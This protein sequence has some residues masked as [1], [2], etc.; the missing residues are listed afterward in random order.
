MPLT[1]AGAKTT[2]DQLSRTYSVA[3]G[4]Q[5]SVTATSW[6]DLSTIYTIPAGDAIPG[7]YNPTSVTYRLTSGGVG[8]WGNGESLQFRG[9]IGSNN[10]GA[11]GSSVDGSALA[12]G[13]AFRWWC[14]VILVVDVTGASGS[15]AALLRG[16]IAESANNLI[17]GTAADNSV[18]FTA[19]VQAAGI[20]T[21]TPTTFS[22]QVQWGGSAG[23]PTV[24]SYLTLYEK[25]GG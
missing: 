20:N 3:D 23:S 12:N 16:A 5:H 25:L 10:V 8:S 7:P 11:S 15:A 2:G 22:I 4:I 6:A 18:A 14:E 17:P 19:A 21:T 13:A 9:A 24:T 1:P